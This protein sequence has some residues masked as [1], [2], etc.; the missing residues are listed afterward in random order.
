[1]DIIKNRT[2]VRHYIIGLFIAIIVLSLAAGIAYQQVKNLEESADLVTHSMLVDKEINS[3]FSNYSLIKSTQLD[4]AISK[5]DISMFLLKNYEEQSQETIDR[6]KKLTVGDKKQQEYIAKLMAL[7]ADLNEQMEMILKSKKDSL[8]SDADN[9]GRLERITTIMEEITTVKEDMIAKGEMSL[10]SNKDSYRSSA[11]Y[12]PLTILGIAIISIIVFALAFWKILLN[13]GRMQRTQEFLDNMLS[14]TDNVISHYQPVRNKNHEI[15]DFTILYNNDILFE[16]TGY[17]PEAI[18]GDLISEHYPFLFDN[19]FFEML[20][21][22]VESDT[23]LYLERDYNF[24]DTVK[25]FRTTAIKLDDGV[26]TTSV[27]LSDIKKMTSQ[28]EATI[29]LLAQR[30]AVLNAAEIKAKMGNY[31]YVAETDESQISDNYYRILGYQ[32]GEIEL[33]REKMTM[34]IHPDDVAGFDAWMEDILTN[35]EGKEHVFR[36]TSVDGVEKTLYYRLDYSVENDQAVLTG[37]VQDISQDIQAKAH[38]EDQNI[39]L[40][41]SVEELDSFNHVV[42]HDLQEPLRKIQMFISLI[43]DDG[44]MHED[45]KVYFDKIERAAQ[46]M[47]TLIKHLLT[48]SSIGKSDQQFKMVN[49]NTTLEAVATNQSELI[50]EKKVKLT[51][52]QMPT[53]FAISFQMEQLFNNLISNAL[54]YSKPNVSSKILIAS[55]VVNRN[56]IHEDFRK[57]HHHYHRIS[58]IDNGTGFHQDHA[59][60]IFE[61]F[62]RLHH[63]SDYSGTGIGLAICRK[64]MENHDGHI[65]AVGVENQGAT[66]IIYLPQE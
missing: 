40:K 38:L 25:T 64:I 13:R 24:L 37:I 66:F 47:Q 28:L 48:Y 26:T 50:A 34:L 62:Q 41:R 4:Y 17:R 20:K 1:M 30:N 51:I 9:S 31:R 14:S 56:Q 33:N 53:V 15:V 21:T 60:K 23:V 65:S 10:K 3:L 22:C 55:E 7:K 42:S 39:E 63:S 58:V 32:P 46:R 27:D 2:T 18:R 59:D 29:Q 16:A 49:L 19:G 43:T 36:I 5:K 54:K 44:Q 35:K 57:K 6:L 52:K 45:I 11:H 8:V 61:L 12:T